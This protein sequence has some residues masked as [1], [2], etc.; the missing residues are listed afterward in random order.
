MYCIDYDFQNFNK[1]YEEG[2]PLVLK[3]LI[4]R[5]EE[6]FVTPLVD[7]I[8]AINVSTE[9]DRRLV[10]I[11]STLSSK[12]REHLIALLKDFKDIFA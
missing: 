2:I 9:E 10:Q 4:N 3:H 6:R 11:G 8:F 7:E 5:E 12:E 1:N